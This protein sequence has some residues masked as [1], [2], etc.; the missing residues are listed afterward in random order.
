MDLSYFILPAAAA[1]LAAALLAMRLKKRGEKLFAAP[2]T[3]LAGAILG[4]M[5]AKVGY[6]LLLPHIVWPQ[7]GLGA[8]LRMQ[9]SEFSFFG[10]CVGLCLGAIL[11]GKAAKINTGRMLDLTAPS[12]SLMVCA[13]R[14][15]EY[16][17]GMLGMGD[18]L[19]NEALWFF[20]IGI[21]DEWG[22]WYLAVFMLEAAAAAI[23]LAVYL[24]KEK[25]ARLPE[26]F[27]FARMAFYLC[28]P[29][30]LLE[31]LRVECI[32]WGFVRLEQVLCGI[33]V[34]AVLWLE[35]RRAKGRGAGR[36]RPVFGALICILLMVVVEFALDKFNPS[37]LL[38]YGV[39]ALLLFC[40]ALMERYSV[41][42]TEKET[43]AAV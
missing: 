2:L 38:C 4:F 35:C 33:C 27:L 39:M 19:E 9:P 10:G 43:G 30:I 26:G 16:H 31:S 13:L 22:D 23:C 32:K 12:L 5:L 14:L 20:P 42:R 41:K 8:L 7:W 15:S 34:A 11:A 40:I 24:L 17:L 21:T 6:C 25:N 18:E 3:L 36:F 37:T 28:L 1:L 29:Q